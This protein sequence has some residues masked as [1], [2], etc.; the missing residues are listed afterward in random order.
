MRILSPI[1]NLG[2]VTSASGLLYRTDKK[3]DFLTFFGIKS[4]KHFFWKSVLWQIET[5]CGYISSHG[6]QFNVN[7]H[8]QISYCTFSKCSFSLTLCRAN[9][10]LQNFLNSPVVFVFVSTQFALGL[11]F[12]VINSKKP[13]TVSLE[14]FVFIPFAPAVQSDNTWLTSNFI[15]PSFSFVYQQMP[16][17]YTKTHYLI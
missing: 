7:E 5:I 14:L 6:L 17:P 11:I 10:Y 1:C 2:F 15:K 3:S 16:D 9:F 8:F 4:T 12:L 13:R